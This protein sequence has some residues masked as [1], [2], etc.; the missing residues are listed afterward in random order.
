M[1]IVGLRGLSYEDKTKVFIVLGFSVVFL[2]I[3]GALIYP[4]M[5]HGTNI[6]E[7]ASPKGQPLLIRNLTVGDVSYKD[8]VALNP[9][10]NNLII[11]SSKEGAGNVTITLET[12]GWCV[13]L[14]IWGGKEKGW[15]LKSNCSRSVSLSYYSFDVR[16]A[17]ES[18]ELYWYLGAGS[19]LVFHKEGKIDN[20]E[21][22]AFKVKYKGKED[23]GSFLVS[24]GRR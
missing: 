21:K 4:I 11:H 9:Y 2:G 3:L 24:L 23:E 14:W 20:Y 10:Y 1:V 7:V 5:S 22:V 17:H 8:V 6:F 18:G 15:V 16:P 12:P 13:D 19:M